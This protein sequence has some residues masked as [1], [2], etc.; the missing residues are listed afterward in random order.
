[1]EAMQVI[2]VYVYTLY[3]VYSHISSK[4]RFRRSIIPDRIQYRILFIISHAMYV[5]QK[6]ANI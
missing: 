5:I 1:M 4:T 3:N 2:Y 6:I